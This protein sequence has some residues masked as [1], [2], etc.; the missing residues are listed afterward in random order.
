MTGATIRILGSLRTS[1]KTLPNAF[2]L[3]YLLNVFQAPIER[4]PNRLEPSTAITASASVVLISAVP[5]RK[6]GKKALSPPCSATKPKAPSGNI[7]NQLLMRIKKNT[8]SAIGKILS[9]FA[10]LPVI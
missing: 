6:N 8:A 5:L 3:T 1:V 7:P 10:R 4:M 2:R 9:D